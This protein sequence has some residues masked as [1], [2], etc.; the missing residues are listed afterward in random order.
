M[1]LFDPGLPAWIGDDRLCRVAWNRLA[2]PAD[3]AVIKV[4]NRMEV[5][6]ALALLLAGEVHGDPELES[7]LRRWS[8]RLRTVDPLRDVHNA[9][10]IG[11]R[12]LIPGDEEWPEQLDHLEGRAPVCLWAQGAGRPDWS[13][14]VAIVGS[15]AA[16]HYGS[17]VAADLATGLAG[18]GVTIVSGGA[19]GIDIAAHR[20]AVIA[21]GTTVAVLAGGLDRLY[22]K[23]N[24]QMLRHLGEHHLLL[25]ESPP[26]TSSARWRFLERNRLIA[27]LSGAVV[28]VEAAW[29]SGALNTANHAGDFGRP[30]G[31]VPGPITSAMSA[32]CHRLLRDSAAQCITDVQ[33]VL[34]LLGL[35]NPAES[36]WDDGA[37]HDPLDLRVYDAMAIG[38]GCAPEQLATEV[39]VEVAQV[40]AA[41]GRL[42]LSGH[43]N[44]TAGQWRRHGNRGARATG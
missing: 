23:G 5:S 44:L 29:R 2:D 4:R 22:P 11:G 14:S 43:V 34:E 24:E 7:L 1:T 13:R 39:G 42:E 16:T 31:A 41:L 25:T 18:H 20:G 37:V 12:V 15:R 33:D 3:S 30:L 10:L 17:R 40:L 36:S 21:G 28:V 38:Q 8:A 19:F 35:A 6:R 9:G 27:G 26:G 32:G